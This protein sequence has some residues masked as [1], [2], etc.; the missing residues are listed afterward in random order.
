MAGVEGYSSLHLE[1][2][3]I[4]PVFYLLL[5]LCNSLL[6]SYMTSSGA[7]ALGFG[8]QNMFS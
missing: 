6:H 3:L 2:L 4:V 1:K 5:S 7:A 8:L